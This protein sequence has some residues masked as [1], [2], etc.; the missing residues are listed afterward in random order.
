M[1]PVEHQRF[2]QRL[3][4]NLEGDDR[5]LALVAL[6]STALADRCDPYSDHDCWVVVKPGAKSALCEDIAWL[7][8]T[9]EVVVAIRP[10]VH[11]LVVLYATGH[12]VEA[13]IFEPHELSEGKLESY[14]VLFDRG[15]TEEK[16]KGIAAC[17]A[18][19][20][21]PEENISECIK[22]LIA[23]L[24]GASRAAR[25]EFLS[26]H[27]YLRCFVPDLLL[28]LLARYKNAPGERLADPLDPWRR[29]EQIDP[30]LAAEML[31][32]VELP[33]MDAALPLLDL[34]DRELGAVLPG[35]PVEAAAAV[36][37]ALNQL[38][39]Q[40]AVSTDAD[41]SRPVTPP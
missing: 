15:D 8:D 35:Y 12:I 13:G 16:L 19:Q 40:A 41:S 38:C 2:T 5:V 17:S 20:P 21:S 31:A 26:A 33:L 34:A 27:K 37:R 23:L 6:G 4:A 39:R 18:I 3:Q 28:G 7:P 22:A 14:A 24:T 11:Y 36:R 30:A 29:W 9:E 32:A 1:T 25:G 10:G